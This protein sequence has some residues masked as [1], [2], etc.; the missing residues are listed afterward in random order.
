MVNTLVFQLFIDYWSICD[1]QLEEI[2]IFQK[3]NKLK[4]VS[5]D[6]RT[7]INMPKICLF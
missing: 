4:K 6:T 5:S 3:N 2:K 1:K 7:Y